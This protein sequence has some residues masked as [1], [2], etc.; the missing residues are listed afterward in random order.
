MFTRPSRIKTQVHFL[1]RAQG[2]HLSGISYRVENKSQH[3]FPS[4]SFLS[5][6]SSDFDRPVP[7]LEF[8]RDLSLSSV[9]SPFH[10]DNVGN[11]S[12]RTAHAIRCVVTFLLCS[13]DSYQPCC[14]NPSRRNMST[15]TTSRSTPWHNPK[16]PHFYHADD[17]T[18][19]CPYSA[20]KSSWN[21][22]GVIACTP[23]AS[24]PYPHPCCSGQS[25]LPSTNSFSTV[26][27]PHSCRLVPH[28][29]D[30]LSKGHPSR[31]Y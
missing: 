7:A 9:S 14:I 10:N 12:C 13:L 16:R 1:R 21:G 25:P 22:N 24:R 6:S 23:I 26:P 2:R 15:R 20:N 30:S 11:R 17:T 3:F 31:E 18:H 27:P 29:R 19:Y 28:H 5:C 8:L 4:L